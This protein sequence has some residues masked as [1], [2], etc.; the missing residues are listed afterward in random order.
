MPTCCA[1]RRLRTTTSSGRRS[2]ARRATRACT[3]SETATESMT[4]VRPFSGRQSS[5]RSTC[6]RWNLTR[7]RLRIP[8]AFQISPPTT[9]R[10][11]PSFAL[12]G[13]VEG[14]SALQTLTC[15]GIRAM[16]SSSYPRPAHSFASQGKS[17]YRM[18]TFPSSWR[19]TST[20]FPS[21]ASTSFSPRRPPSSARMRKLAAPQKGLR[22][23]IVRR[24][25]KRPR[26]WRGPS[27]GRHLHQRAPGSPSRQHR[28]R[29][30]SHLLASSYSRVLSIP[31]HRFSDQVDLRV[32]PHLRL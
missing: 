24:P 17:L 3:R 10:F 18:V 30:R 2:W 8:S 21:R 6:V 13:G 28:M 16:K 1:C 29:P 9:W 23:W 32:S 31:I 7:S 15:F 27:L 19:E 12:A 20:L 25:T 11:S 14:A 4:D 22:A 26:N 5:R